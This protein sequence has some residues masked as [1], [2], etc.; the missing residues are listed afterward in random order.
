MKVRRK[1]SKQSGA[2]LKSCPISSA[3]G[4]STVRPILG[5]TCRGRTRLVAGAK[6]E[7]GRKSSWTGLGR[8]AW[9]ADEQTGLRG[10]TIHELSRV[11]RD[12]CFWLGMGRCCP[13]AG[14]PCTGVERRWNVVWGCPVTMGRHGNRLHH[15]ATPCIPHGCSLSLRAELHPAG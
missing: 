13:A 8:V 10:K 3:P 14:S 15:L 9:K 1:R 11:I 5:E 7:G 12:Q 4:K 6:G 2:A